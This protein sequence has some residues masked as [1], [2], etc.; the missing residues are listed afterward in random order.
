MYAYT[1]STNRFSTSEHCSTWP[2]LRIPKSF[3][4][5]ARQLRIV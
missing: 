5:I 1:V 3:A 4:S 2:D